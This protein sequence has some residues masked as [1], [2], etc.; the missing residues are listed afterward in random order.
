VREQCCPR[1][2]AIRFDGA[3][4][5]RISPAL[6]RALADP[7]LAGIIVCPSNPY[8][9]VDPVLAV[10]GLRDAL[11]RPGVPIV[12][13]SPIVG[14]QAI[15][16]PTAKI[17]GELGLAS[18]TA[19]VARHYDGLIDGFVIDALD[20]GSRATIDGPVEI[21]QTVMRSLDDRIALAR[22]CLAFCARLSE[23]RGGRRSP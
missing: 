6:A 1:V 3:G 14:G 10:P 9:S 12:A 2:R 21:A 13:V 5:A 4:Q 20:A 18:D 19:T 15:K 7:R 17:M 22:V 8:L 16:G 23:A 11:R